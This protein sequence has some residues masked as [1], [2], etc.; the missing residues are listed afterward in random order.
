MDTPLC[1][2]KD[3][4]K[5]EDLLEKATRFVSVGFELDIPVVDAK[6]TPHR[7][8]QPEI[9]KIQFESK[10]DK[11]KALKEKKKLK[12]SGA[13][14][15]VYI[16]SSQTHTQRIMH[17]NTKALLDVTGAGNQL[18]MTGSGSL[19]PKDDEAGRPTMAA[20]GGPRSGG[21]RQGE[22]RNEH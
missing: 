2:G 16:R 8:G 17:L 1:K 18:R 12:D 20:V 21:Q 10:G 13:Y 5:D 22:G 6:R 14:N 9:V 11:I 4:N 15:R 7:N 19:I 3:S